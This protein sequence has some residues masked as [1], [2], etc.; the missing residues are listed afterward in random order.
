MGLNIGQYNVRRAVQIRASRVQVWREFQDILRMNAWFGL[1]HDLEVYEA[2]LGGRV[3]LS[4][5]QDGL[6]VGFGGDILV[7]EEA[8]ELSFEDNWFGDR[9][10]VVPTFI[11]IR[12]TTAYDGT[13]VELFHHGFERLGSDGDSEYL[14]YESGWDVHHLAALKHIVEGD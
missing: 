12:L 14:A 2:H 10:W 7:F 1:G 5:E 4:I 6:P 8:R 13:L 11:T 9:A 3:E